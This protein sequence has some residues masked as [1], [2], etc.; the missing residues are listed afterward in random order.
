MKTITDE[1]KT[2]HRVWK[3]GVIFALVALASIRTEAAVRLKDI[4][5][6]QG[7]H[8]IQLIG[9]GLVVGLDR[10]GDRASG[11]Q[12]VVFTVQSVVNM[13]KRMGITVPPDEVTLRNV[14]SVVVT[15]RLS[16][17]TRTGSTID[18]TVSSMGDATS[19]Q[20]GT[21]LMTPLFGPSDLHTPYAIAQG[22]LSIG[23]FNISVGGEQVQR[24]HALVGRIPNGAI[25]ERDLPPLAL[26]SDSLTIS[27][28]EPDYTTA[29]RIASAIRQ[30]FGT[31]T[32][33]PFDAGTVIVNVPA[34]R[35][36]VRGLVGFIADL[37]ALTVTPDAIARIVV[38]E[39]TGTVVAG[40]N[41]TI[42][43]VA[44]AHGNLS[45]EVR[46]TP[47]ISQPPPFAQ[48]GETVV[49]PQQEVTAVE[50]QAR[51]VS[52]VE[53]ANVGDVAKVLN[54]LGVA[55]RDLI[56]IFQALKQAGALRAELIV[57]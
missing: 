12:G 41:V 53:T 39:K 1:K 15:A 14:A 10:T 13:L 28:F 40:E 26:T 9:H 47:I 29:N 38:N 23:G 11:N 6:V 48:R 55:P 37:E 56:A 51:L 8:E 3:I 34:D 45:V 22:P 49:V 54:A 17:F 20:G 42:S 30:R 50:E 25:V 43:A 16:P 33:T 24:N 31:E 52:F 4:A 32:A 35:R 21:L 5:R 2:A 57:L 18:V 46:T 44:V 27:L 19:L 7:A 36:G